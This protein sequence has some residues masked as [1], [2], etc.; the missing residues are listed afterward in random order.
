MVHR[1]VAA[2]GSGGLNS[3]AIAGIA[4]GSVVAVAVVAGLLVLLVKR[5]PG[6]NVQPSGDA[7]TSELGR[8]VLAPITAARLHLGCMTVVVWAAQAWRPWMVAS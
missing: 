8:Q 3:G 6:G 4:V 1:P 5:R 7:M 2:K